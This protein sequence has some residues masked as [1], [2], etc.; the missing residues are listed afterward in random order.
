MQEVYYWSPCLTK[1]GTYRATINSAISL[2]NYSKNKY[3]IKIINSCGEWSSENELLKK[4]NVEVINLGFNYYRFLPKTGYLKSR[5]SYTVIFLLSI[6]PLMRLLL[7]KK[8]SFLIIH[9]L[10]F[11]PLL[12]NLLKKS[13]TRII[14]RI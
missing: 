9:L 11:L 14:L 6:V 10:T 2:A 8:P 1:V 5:F 13:E 3:S 4:N 12:I 7:K